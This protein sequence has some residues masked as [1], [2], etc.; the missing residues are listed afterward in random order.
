MASDLEQLA[1]YL[2]ELGV[3]RQSVTSII[4]KEDNFQAFKHKL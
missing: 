4:E 3:F 1:H 2:Y